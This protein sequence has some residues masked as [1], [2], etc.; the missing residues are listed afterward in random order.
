MAKK[1]TK[2][3]AS[4]YV[5]TCGELLPLGVESKLETSEANQTV[6]VSS[7]L[8]QRQLHAK[9]S[10]ERVK[11]EAGKM[12]LGIKFPK[13]TFEKNVKRLFRL[14]NYQ[15]RWNR[16]SW[17]RVGCRLR[18]TPDGFLEKKCKRKDSEGTKLLFPVDIKA[19]AHLRSAETAAKWA[20]SASGW[21]RKTPQGAWTVAASSDTWK[22][23]Q[24]Y[25]YIFGTTSGYVAMAIGGQPYL[26]QV[27]RDQGFLDT[28]LTEFKR[29]V[30]ARF[31]TSGRSS[32]LPPDMPV[33]NLEVGH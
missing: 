29:Y 6:R 8:R 24:M 31:G 33:R 2:L 11:N 3:R 5:N 17:R 16:L 19:S 15:I 22:Q 23:V 14:K 30:N 13:K 25:C 27:A 1:T 7:V 21:L 12:A 18:G 10:S 28:L 4:E 9:P 32:S 26:L 20:K